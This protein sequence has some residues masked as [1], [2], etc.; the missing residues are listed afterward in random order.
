MKRFIVPIMCW[1]IAAGAGGAI[2]SASTISAPAQNSMDVQLGAYFPNT[3]DARFLGGQTQLTAGLDYTLAS[4]SGSTPS[5]T[6]A[7]FDY[8]SGSKNSGY[9]HS[10]GLGL[11]YR[12]VGM[13]FVGAGLGLY[14]TSVKNEFG[15]TGNVTGAGGKVFAGLSLGGGSTVEL[16]YH[17]MP[18]TLG[19]NPSGLGLEVGFHL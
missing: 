6:N 11:E 13:G 14:N 5:A 7:F 19:V 2:A 12:T 18:S 10:G 3:A 1:L 8:L 16:D 17:V 15:R 4:S 9:V